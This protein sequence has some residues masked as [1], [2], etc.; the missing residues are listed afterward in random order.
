[1]FPVLVLTLAV[2]SFLVRFIYLVKFR[3][4]T[5]DGR[6]LKYIEAKAI[7]TGAS[8]LFIVIGAA[9]LLIAGRWTLAVVLVIGCVLLDRAARLYSYR[10]AVKE[11]ASWLTSIP[12]ESRHEMA[13]KLVDMEIKDGTKM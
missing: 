10:R 11:R 6:P 7:L 13:A 12:V 1:M 2:V 3:Y 4:A 9:I 5:P 8:V